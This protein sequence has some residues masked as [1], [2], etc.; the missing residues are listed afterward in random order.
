[1]LAEALLRYL[2]FI[3]IF[4]IVTTVL[5]EWSI[6]KPELKRRDIRRLSLIDGWYGLSAITAVG[7]GLVLWFGLGKPADFYTQNWIFMLKLSLAILLGILSIY[8]TIFFF[9]NRKGPM[10]ELV[11]IPRAVRWLVLSEI[12]LL[13]FIPLCA[14]IMARGIGI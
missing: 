12:I 11:E 2:H 3:S 1:M 5:M 7:A 8:P 9:R 4:V 10:D 14:V 13:I 6:L